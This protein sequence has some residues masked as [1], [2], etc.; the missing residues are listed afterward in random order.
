MAE[1]KYRQNAA[2]TVEIWRLGDFRTDGAT[3]MKK[4]SVFLL[5]TVAL[6]FGVA[7]PALST[8]IT[9]TINL[10][11]VYAGNTP[12]GTPPWL[13]ATFTSS[14]GSTTGTLTLTSH[15]S[16]SD[17]L[18]GLNSKKSTVGW[19]FYLNQSLV[20]LTCESGGT[21]ADNNALFG[22]SY[23]A[24]PVPGTFNLA[25]GWSSK[26]RF[27]AGSS[28]I[29]DLTFMSSLTGNPF[30]PN[31]GNWWS[32]AHVQG[33]TGECSGWIVSGDGSGASGSGP[34]TRTPPPRNV[35]EPAGLGVFGI[36]LLAIGLFLGLRR[37]MA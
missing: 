35:P 23:N 37:R 4:I 36:G 3:S 26:N 11:T 34:C 19:A 8:P 13:T 12:D 33:I 25:F 2:G 28:A 6:A 29:Y 24:G 21:C 27:V 1:R 5:F 20:S 9:T 32:V 30:G 17:F 7:A 31:G 22:G 14:T 15:L 18:Q 16:A 10:G